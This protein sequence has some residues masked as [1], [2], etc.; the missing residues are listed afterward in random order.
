MSGVVDDAAEYQA[1]AAN[2]EI[3]VGRDRTAEC[4]IWPP[5]GRED[6]VQFIYPLSELHGYRQNEFVPWQL[7]ALI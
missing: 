7:G 2:K 4:R 1:I 5:N 6:G 3:A